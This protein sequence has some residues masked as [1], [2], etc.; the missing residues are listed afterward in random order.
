MRRGALGVKCRFQNLQDLCVAKSRKVPKSV[1]EAHGI[2]M[3]L[4]GVVDGLSSFG[5]QLV[6]DTHKDESNEQSSAG[7]AAVVSLRA[8]VSALVEACHKVQ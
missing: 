5:A 1:F 2:A 3:E 4:V 6:S 7:R 8:K